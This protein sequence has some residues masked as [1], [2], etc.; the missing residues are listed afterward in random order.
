MFS[1]TLDSLTMAHLAECADGQ[2]AL[3]IPS[4]SCAYYSRTR[5]WLLACPSKGFCLDSFDNLL[6]VCNKRD[7]EEEKN[8]RTGAVQ[9]TLDIGPLRSL[10][11]CSNNIE[12]KRMFRCDS[13]AV[14]DHIRKTW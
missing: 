10:G 14:C 1:I 8:P 6:E 3:A 12:H 5:W 4:R 13:L 9:V 11:K 2:A 7:K